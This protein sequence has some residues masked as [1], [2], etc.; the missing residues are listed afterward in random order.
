VPQ[1]PTG[2]AGAAGAGFS[3]A[4]AWSSG[5][6]Y[7]TNQIVSYNGSAWISIQSSNTG[8]APPTS[9]TFW[10]VLAEGFNFRAAYLGSNSYNAYDVVTS[11]GS[12]YMCVVAASCNTETPAASITA[13]DGVWAL[14]AQAGATGA[15]GPAG[16]TVTIGTTTTGA[17]GSTAQVTN[18]G[19]SSAAILNFTVPQGPTGPTGATGSTGLT[20]SAG[21]TGPAGPTGNTGPTGQNG[22]PVYGP[23]TVSFAGSS[24]EPSGGWPG[25]ASPIY[26]SLSSSCESTSNTICNVT[27]IPANGNLSSFSFTFSS[28][29]PSGSTYT[30]FLLVNGVEPTFG[31]GTITAGANTVTVSGPFAVT[32][33]QTIEL[34]VEL[35]SGSSEDTGT[36]TTAAAESLTNTQLSNPFMVVGNKAFAASTTAAVAFPVSYTNTGTYF[37]V[38][39][40]ASNTGQTFK[41]V[42]TSA[43]GITITAATSNSDTVNFHCIG[44]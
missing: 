25:T 39:T 16:F 14:F 28:N 19:N 4:Q 35:T 29:V 21:P 2:P 23:G 41:V 7:S 38:V 34:E 24:V 6:T 43:S 31:S 40:D 17:P 11:S 30:V 12:T 9:P 3:W 33:G 20:G 26:V 32:A 5:T 42:N 22:L 36:S 27:T 1:G 15:T 37:C 44:Y 8:N 13:A 10:Q 18:T